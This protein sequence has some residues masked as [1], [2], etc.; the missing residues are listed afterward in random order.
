MRA[1][2]PMHAASARAMAS[3][4]SASVLGGAQL[5]LY[6]VVRTLLQ[7]RGYSR[8]CRYSFFFNVSLDRTEG[9]YQNPDCRN[10]Q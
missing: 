1:V 7:F 8:L 9:D 4:T 5:A 6:A 3:E 2:I 10:V